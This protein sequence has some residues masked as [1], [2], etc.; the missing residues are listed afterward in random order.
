MGSGDTWN[1]GLRQCLSRSIRHE[2]TVFPLFVLFPEYIIGLDIL[3][4][5]Q[6]G[7]KTV[8]EEELN[9]GC[10]ILVPYQS[11]SHRNTVSLRNQRLVLWKTWKIQV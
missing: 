2:N 11:I 10:G 1:F 8:K 6:N 5:F 4:N 9:G 7:K 3:S